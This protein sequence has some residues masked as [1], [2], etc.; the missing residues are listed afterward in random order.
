MKILAVI[1]GLAVSAILGLAALAA[2]LLIP[3]A[4]RDWDGS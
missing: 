1:V 4:Q 2:R 3:E